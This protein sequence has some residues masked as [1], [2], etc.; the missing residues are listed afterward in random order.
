MG[1]LADDGRRRSAEVRY[2]A[3][4]PAFL[5][6]TAAGCAMLGYLSE[7]TRSARLLV[8]AF[9]PGWLRVQKR[10]RGEALRERRRSFAD[11]QR[12]RSGPAVG[13]RLVGCRSR[14]G[15]RL[16]VARRRCRDDIVNDALGA[17]LASADDP[18]SGRQVSRNDLQRWVLDPGIGKAFLDRFQ[19]VCAHRRR[20]SCG[21]GTAA[22]KKSDRER[23]RGRAPGAAG[24]ER[25]RSSPRRVRR[26][27]NHRSDKG[28]K[29]RVHR[30]LGT[31]ANGDPSSAHRPGENAAGGHGPPARRVIDSVSAASTTTQSRPRSFA[32]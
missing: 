11:H 28:S 2:R 12:H 6:S 31:R 7:L 25:D 26:A 23:R 18:I 4:R 27:R 13:S 24:T 32:P 16:G 20:A 17:T 8:S 30:P 14:L 29:A 1:R 22:R 21:P 19:D 3:G 9:D 15:R 5:R 10:P